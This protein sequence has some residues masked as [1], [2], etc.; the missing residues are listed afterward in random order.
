MGTYSQIKH[1][2]LKN[3]LNVVKVTYVYFTVG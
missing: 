3:S 1:E 2:G